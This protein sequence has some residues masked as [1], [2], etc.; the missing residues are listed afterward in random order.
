M[1]GMNCPTMPAKTPSG[2]QNGTSMNQKNAAWKKAESVASST[3]ET[4]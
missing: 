3:F 1:V 4:T 2:N